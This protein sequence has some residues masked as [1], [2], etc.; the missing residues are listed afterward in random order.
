MKA[1]ILR[2]DAP[3]VS[4]GT[5][6]VDHHGFTD[7]FPGLAMLTGL[8]GNALGWEHGDF[9][10]LQNLQARLDFAARWDVLANP[11][12][13]YHTVDLGA[14]KMRS[15]GWTTRGEPEHRAGGTA[16]RYGTHQRYRHYLADGLMTIALGLKQE[17]E[18][19]LPTIKDALDRPAR[20]LF[21]GRKTCL[22]ARPLLDPFNPVVEGTSLVEILKT[23][24]VWGRDGREV[25]KDG[26]M[27]ACWTP[28][29]DEQM[30]RECREVYDLRDWR[31]QIHAGNRL[32]REGMLEVK[33]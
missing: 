26:K 13:D 27:Y 20:P 12:I 2:L 8:V 23:I 32:R 11:M 14:D 9:R 4:F 28:T 18:P 1:L 25:A 24:P 30:A 10:K 7:N 19:G 6:L 21:I 5:V 22:P 15:G 33:E 17:G 3:F 16:A 29:E 31:N